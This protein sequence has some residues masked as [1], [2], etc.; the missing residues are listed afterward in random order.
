MKTTD[1]VAHAM[2]AGAGV[3]VRGCCPPFRVTEYEGEDGALAN[4]SAKE[5]RKMGRARQDGTGRTQTPPCKLSRLGGSSASPHPSG[6]LV[7]PAPA[8]APCRAHLLLLGQRGPHDRE[9]KH[10]QVVGHQRVGPRVLAQGGDQLAH[11]QLP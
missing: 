11:A 9:H 5:G 10:P 2:V 3:S 4:Y 7:P 6:C 1:L 8:P